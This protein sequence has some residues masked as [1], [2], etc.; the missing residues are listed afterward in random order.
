VSFVPRRATDPGSVE[1]RTARGVWLR[2]A[3]YRPH[4]SR[5]A[6]LRHALKDA[7]GTQTTARVVRIA[8]TAPASD[9]TAADYELAYRVFLANGDV[10]NAQRIAQTAVDRDPQSIPWRERLAQVAEW[11][12]RQDV[13]LANYLA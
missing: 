5:G 13:A 7:S 8:T 12:R 2:A 6:A 9:A 4:A 3:W 10:A 1:H 11:N